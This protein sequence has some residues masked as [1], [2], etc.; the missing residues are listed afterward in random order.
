[1]PAVSPPWLGL[2]REA[3]IAA[4]D[5]DGPAAR[6]R[7]RAAVERIAREHGPAE[8]PHVL[9]AWVDTMLLAI[10]AVGAPDGEGGYAYLDHP[11]CMRFTDLDT[12]ASTDNADDIPPAAAWAA[13][14]INSR[15]VGD[16]ATFEALI[17]AQS[18]DAEWSRNVSTLLVMCALNLGQRAWRGAS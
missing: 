2:A 1:M 13:R 4:T 17:N 7:A 6:A 14:V 5:I 15:A 11:M 9:L 10:G 3:L 16:Q 12:D 18:S 8:I